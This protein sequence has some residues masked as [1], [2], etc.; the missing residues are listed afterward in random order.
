MR[1]ALTNLLAIQAGLTLAVAAGFYVY[2]GG[3]SAVSAV[4]GGAIALVV[5]SMLAFR[6][7]RAARP[8]AGVLGLYL[9]TFERFLFIGA[10]FAFAIAVLKLLPVPLLAGFAGAEIGYF[11]AAAALRDGD[12]NSGRTDGG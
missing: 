2:R 4:Y 8:G 10:A 5:T 9:G 12:T 11:F 3:F 1:K 7:A 6:L